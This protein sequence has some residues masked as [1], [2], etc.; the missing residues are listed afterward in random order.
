MI[1][2]PQEI[3]NFSHITRGRAAI[4]Q[5]EHSMEIGLNTEEY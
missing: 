3:L 5:I 4:D 2:K 1:L